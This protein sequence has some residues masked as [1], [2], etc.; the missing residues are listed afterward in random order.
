MSGNFSV[1][2]PFKSNDAAVVVS[3]TASSDEVDA[4]NTETADCDDIED[5]LGCIKSPL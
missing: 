3:S 4:C 5:A 1:K 2:Y